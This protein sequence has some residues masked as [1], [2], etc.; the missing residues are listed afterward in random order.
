MVRIRFRQRD[1]LIFL[2]ALLAGAVLVAGCGSS[3]S[4]TTTTT[5]GTP[6]AGGTFNFPLTAEPVSIEPLNTQE[7]EGFQVNHQV[8]EGLA[9]YQLQSDGSMKAVPDIA[10]SW[11]ANA[12]ATVWTFKL[13]HGVMF[14][15]PVS[16]EVHAQDFVDDWNYVTDP[17]NQSIVSYVMAPIKGADASGYAKNGLVGVKALD[18]YTLQVTL[19]YSFAEFPQTLGH[20]VTTAFPLDYLKKIGHKAFMN[21][22]VGT[23]P[24]MVEKWVHN[25]SVDLVKNPDWWDKSQGGPYV[26]A[27][28]FPIILDTNTEWLEFQKGAID[29]TS[30]P[31]GQVASSSN[32]PQVKNGTWEAKK[33]PSLA[34]YFIGMNMKNADLGGAQNLPL[35][36]AINY[37][38]DRNAVINV[39]N[40][41]VP[42][43]PNGVVPVGIPGQNLS[44]LPY[45]YDPTKAKQLVSQIGTVPTL[46]YWYNTDPGHQKIAEALQAGW[47]NVGIKV[48]LNNFEW[49]TFL[50]KLQQGTQDQLF[51]MGWIADYPSM[52]NFLY[53]LFQSEQAKTGS[54]T[55]YSNPQFDQL[56][57]QARSTVDD[58]QRHNLYAQAEKIMLTDA[59]IVPLYFYR[60]YRITNVKRVGG[61][62]INPMYFVDMWKVWVK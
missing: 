5:G 31:P 4:T 38:A 39:V 26:D 25:Q 33:W 52:D 43:V 23:G 13:K 42:L 40:E 59:P 60:D 29:V 56:L 49:G 48:N 58:T 7:S 41:G 37:A 57:V 1:A 30:V 36:Q 62:S 61:V 15:A 12:D 20:P 22:P 11:S 55:F 6:K 45:P 53:P 32:L 18:D 19:N 10:E 51:R 2:V 24:Y 16:R 46:Q 44:S 14:Q 28:H 34:V 3:G 35:R 9:R 54:Y 8:F 21:K 27:I 47:A 17:A 50:S